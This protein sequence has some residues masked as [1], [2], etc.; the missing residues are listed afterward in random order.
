[1]KLILLLF[2]LSLFS[3]AIEKKNNVDDSKEKKVIS[4]EEN[5]SI[6]LANNVLTDISFITDKYPIEGEV[7]IYQDNV[8][9]TPKPKQ[10]FSAASS[11]EIRLHKLGQIR[12]IYLGI[13]P[14][15]AWPMAI[16]F[17]EESKNLGM[18]TF[19]PN[20][21]IINSQV[22]DYN[23]QESKFVFKIEK[24][25]Q[26]SSSEIFVSQL[27]K[28]NNSWVI[29][30]SGESDLENI[31]NEFYDF[32]ASAGPASGTSLV[33]LNLNS[34]NKT[35]MVTNNFGISQIKLRI[36]FARAWAATRRSLLIAGYKILDEDRNEGKFYLE[37]SFKRTLL[38]R[39]PS[40]S[41]VQVS[42]KELN[43]E[44]CLISTDLDLENQEISEEII[45]Q[46]NQA[47]S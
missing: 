37:Y 1:M 38:N 6:L 32:L 25:L 34:S 8:S 41:Q 22:F 42:V 24:G 14:S 16:Q 3:C 15:A 29:V 26:Q 47:L 27:K 5:N 2:T 45:S 10:L 20:I 23:N 21:G 33:A 17:I 44:E 43:S 11:N 36:N 30:P 35:E 39:G 13:E 31:I 28:S 12:W 9:K 18:D 46:I 4:I 40:I 7:E 19:D